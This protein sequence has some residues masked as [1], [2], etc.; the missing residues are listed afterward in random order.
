LIALV[1]AFVVILALDLGAGGLGA[2]VIAVVG[3]ALGH[4][5]LL[6]FKQHHPAMMHP[7]Q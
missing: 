4:R 6:R 5:A 3:A 1:V 2:A 7:A